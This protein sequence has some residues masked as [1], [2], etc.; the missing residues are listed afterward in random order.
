MENAALLK[1]IIDNAIDG[2]ITTDDSGTIESINP[3]GCKLFDYK[4]DEV[5]GKNIAMLMPP[6]SHERHDKLLHNFKSIGHVSMIGKRREVTGMRKN[7]ITFP[8][9]LGI[10]EVQFLGRK[11]YTGFVH[12]LSREKEA[13]EQLRGYALH[14][15]EQVQERTLRLEEFVKELEGAKEKVSFSL[16]KEK[17]LGQ[18]KSRFV[19]MA[20]H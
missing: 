20:S 5:I 11:V 12:D 19:S 3:S 6:P 1:A 18:L 4:A 14:L 17:E 13:E 10:S 7:G 15:E 8:F 2:I 16:E 9:R